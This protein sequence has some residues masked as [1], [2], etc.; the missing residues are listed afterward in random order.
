MLA[1][2]RMGLKTVIIPHRNEKDLVEIPDKYKQE[3]KFVL[4]KTLD[5]VLDSA[6]VGWAEKKKLF[7]KKSAIKR[8]STKARDSNPPVAA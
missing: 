7:S 5:D 1:A 6:L 2:M 4:A 8:P 3:L